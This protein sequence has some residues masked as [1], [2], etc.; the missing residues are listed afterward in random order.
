MWRDPS[1]TTV[2][3]FKSLKYVSDLHQDSLLWSRDLNKEH[4]YGHVDIPR[5]V[6]YF[7]I[8]PFT[9]SL[10]HT[11]TRLFKSDPFAFCWRFLFWRILA[12]RQ[13]RDLNF[14]GGIVNHKKCKF[15]IECSSQALDRWSHQPFISFQRVCRVKDGGNNHGCG[16]EGEKLKKLLIYEISSNLMIFFLMQFFELST[17][18]FL[19]SCDKIQVGSRSHTTPKSTCVRSIRKIH[20]IC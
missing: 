20:Q 7:T 5:L 11:L 16:C 13:R 4:D 3:F 1:P 9:S 18:F 6:I 10:L 14:L 8:H 15:R 19:I 2:D 17:L 12:F